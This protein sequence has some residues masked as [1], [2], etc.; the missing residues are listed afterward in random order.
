MQIR[1]FQDVLIEILTLE[2]KHFAFKD[3]K[4]PTKMVL[5]FH[6]IRPAKITASAYFPNIPNDESTRIVLPSSGGPG[7][8]SHLQWGRTHPF[9]YAIRSA[10]AWFGFF[11]GCSISVG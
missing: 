7:L 9:I 4:H 11:F 6:P 3:S 2:G 10:G 1:T 5:Y 8:K